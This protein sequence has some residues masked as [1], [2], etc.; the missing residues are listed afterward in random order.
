[1]HIY[2]FSFTKNASLLSLSLFD[3]FASKQ[4]PCTSFTMKK[5]TDSE[6]L[7][8]LS[9]PLKVHV[10][11]CFQKENV[12]IFI[13]AC[14]IAVRSIAP[15]IDKKTTDPCVLVIDEQGNYVISLLSGH[16]GGGNEFAI[17]TAAFLHATPII[18]TAT[19]LNHKFAVD[20]FAKKNNLVISDM[21]L[22]KAVSSAL[23]DHIPVGISGI[24]PD[25]EIPDGLLWNDMVLDDTNSNLNVRN[26]AGAELGISIGSFTE[27]VPFSRT[28]HLIPKQIVLGIGCKRNTHFE[29]LKEYV[30]SILQE[31]HIFTVSVA[32]IA[33]IDL[34]KNEDGLIKLAQYYEVPFVTYSADE[35]LQIPGDF[36]PSSF[37]KSVT[38]VDNV[39]ERAALAFSKADSLLLRKTAKNGMTIAISQLA[40]SLQF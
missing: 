28:L 8:P 11:D 15:F 34:K 22:A 16:I 30:D 37:V 9:K 18:S 40:L 19:D 33:S 32:A 10:S 17:E 3:Y 23:L 36:T 21:N 26:E 4:I 29:T 20:V 1:M 35:L 6:K 2:L 13:S 39:C 38:G 31:N 27:P 5:Y 14:G 25:G 12:L 7:T 24:L